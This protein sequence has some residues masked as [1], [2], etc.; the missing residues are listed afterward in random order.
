MEEKDLYKVLGITDEEKKLK[1]DNFKNVISKKYKDLAKKYHP[2]RWVN[3]TEE[4]RKNAEEKFKNISNAYSV[5]SDD[6]KRQEYDMGGMNFGGSGF[7]PFSDFDPFSFFNGGRKAQGERIIKGE[8]DNAT[9]TITLEEAFN[10]GEKELKYSTYIPCKDCDGTGSKDKKKHTCPNCNGT[11]RIVKTSRNGAMIS[12][13]IMGC[14]HCNGTGEVIDNPC[15][16]CKGSG[17]EYTY[18]TIKIDIPIG[19]NNGQMFCYS[20]MG[21]PPKG[22]NGINGDLYVKFNV[23]EH[24]YFEREGEHL[25]H[26]EAI[27]FEDALLGS[28]IKVKGIDGKEFDIKVPELT[29]DGRT[30][31]FNGS[32][33]KIG[34]RRGDLGVVIKY[35]LPKKLNNKQKDLLKQFKESYK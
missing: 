1:G 13:Q 27:P 9:I 25:L 28:K 33:M 6:Q 3:G 21:R 17:V 15:P 23:K 22:G 35:K 29:E 7:N 8:N 14:P 4:E 2:D 26:Y 10:G 34:N 31:V 16:K 12:Q 20:G 18:K 19:I 24:D 5:L 30:F 32:G 11:G